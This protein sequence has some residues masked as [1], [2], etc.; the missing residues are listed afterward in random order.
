MIKG[1]LR[2]QSGQV[3]PLMP[4]I[5]MVLLLLFGGIYDITRYI[6]FQHDIQSAADAASLA[7][8][9]DVDVVGQYNSQWQL[10]GTSASIDATDATNEAQALFN[11]NLSLLGLPGNTGVT[12]NPT[13][14]VVSPTQYLVTVQVNIPTIFLSTLNFF[15]VGP[16]AIHTYIASESQVAP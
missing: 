2:S 4:V 7:G 12:I 11:D 8:A 16:S 6:V 1:G 13:F 14:Q 5:M 9:S 15:G 3:M 10:I